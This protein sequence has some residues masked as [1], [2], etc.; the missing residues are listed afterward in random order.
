[1]PFTPHRGPDRVAGWWAVRVGVAVAILVGMGLL[2]GCLGTAGT[3]APGA[4][5][6][7]GTTSGGTSNSGGNGYGGDGGDANGGTGGNGGAGVGGNGGNGYGGNGGSGGHGGTGGNGGAGIGGDGTD[8][9]DGGSGGAGVPGGSFA[10]P[11]GLAG[12][13]RLTSRT[14][15]LSGVTAVAAGAGFV[16]RLRTGGPARATVTMDDNL[17]DRVEATVVGDQLILGIKPGMSVRNATLS[18]EVT[19]GQLD[20]LDASGASRV[21]L[22]PTLTSP[23]LRL[24][25]SGASAVTGPVAV[26][27][28]VATVVGAGTLAL[29]GQAQDL[30]FNA[31]GAS[32]LPMAE[33]TVRHLDAT[34]S[35]VSHAVVTVTDTL[36]AQA[37][38]AA[39]LRYRGAPSVI[40]SQTSGMSSIVRD[41]P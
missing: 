35:G 11:T 14:I 32:R 16:V 20:R 30:R 5:G 19:V 10:G 41:S 39:V 27:Q 33:L 25:V 38:G 7:S 18:A 26:G 12:S 40:R 22:N 3:T 36:A 9:A 4:P 23:A 37:T 21:I 24:V 6:P 8:G 17:T 15:D 2:T 34:L 1:M 13:G 31:A 28:V 29:S